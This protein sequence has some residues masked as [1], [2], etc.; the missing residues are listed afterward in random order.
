M[1]GIE[2]LRALLG[3][4]K[5]TDT[6]SELQLDDSRP[7]IGSV[8]NDDSRLSIRDRSPQAAESPAHSKRDMFANTQPR[9][10]LPRVLAEG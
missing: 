5:K 2:K 8:G 1:Q 3:D 4:V 6:T 7:E 10:Q 9:L